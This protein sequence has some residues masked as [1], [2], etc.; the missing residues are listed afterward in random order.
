MWEHAFWVDLGIAWK[1]D[2]LCLAFFGGPLAVRFFGSLARS[3]LWP[4]A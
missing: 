4:L 1:P 3:M 2:D